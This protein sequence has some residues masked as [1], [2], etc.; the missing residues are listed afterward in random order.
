MFVLA[1][2]VFFIA[3]MVSAFVI[4]GNIATHM[5]RIEQV[6]AQRN[7]AGLRKRVIHI[8]VVRSTGKRSAVVLAFP[9]R[10]KP[11]VLATAGSP[12]QIAA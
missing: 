7:G 9:T 10:E 8:G 6:I 11:S 1:S 12:L 2:T 4:Y 3:L 5:P